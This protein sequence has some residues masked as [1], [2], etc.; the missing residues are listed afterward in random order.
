MTRAQ[1]IKLLCSLEGKKSEVSVG[2]MREVWARLTDQIAREWMRSTF[3][4]SPLLVC[5]TNE[6]E[7]KHAKLAA[8]AARAAKRGGGR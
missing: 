2:N 4:P 3:S 7:A 6:A 5:L 8:R 1:A